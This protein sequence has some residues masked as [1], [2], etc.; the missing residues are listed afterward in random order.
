PGPADAAVREATEVVAVVLSLFAPY[1]A[2]EMWERLGYALSVA[3]AGL[4]KADPALLVEEKVTAIVQVDGKVRDR[5]D[6]H[7]TIAPDELEQLARASAA[8]QRAIGE[9]EIGNVIARPTKAVNIGTSG[10]G[11]EW[12]SEA[13]TRLAAP[14]QP[15]RIERVDR[16]G[17]PGRGGP[18]SLPSVGM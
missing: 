8:V 10:C 2:E 11:L 17:T 5:I 14:P 13:E 7:P 15:P 9:R 3:F 12:A 4:R 6:V 16:V 1:T 18:R